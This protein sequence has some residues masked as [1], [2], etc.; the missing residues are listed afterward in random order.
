MSDRT[1]L[2]IDID[3]DPE[4]PSVDLAMLEFMADHVDRIP[5]WEK[6][7]HELFA[8]PRWPILFSSGSGFRP[9]LLTP[10]PEGVRLRV[11]STL[12]NQNCEIQKFI[13]WIRAWIIRGEIAYRHDNDAQWVYVKWDGP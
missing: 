3:V 12:K 2:K 1:Q 10:L 7:E 9:P 11:N 4:I 6:P 13:D 8:C 5:P